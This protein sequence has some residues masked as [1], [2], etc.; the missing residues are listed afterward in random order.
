[1]LSVPVVVADEN[2]CNSLNKQRS[3]SANVTTVQET[4]YT[5]L[6]KP[7]TFENQEALLKR[8]RRSSQT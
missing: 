5:K 4:S 1:M 8:T 3:Q 7:F 6:N 2:Q